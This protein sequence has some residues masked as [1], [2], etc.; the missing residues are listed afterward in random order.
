MRDRLANLEGAQ[1]FKDQLLATFSHELRTL[2]NTHL[3]MIACAIEQKEVTSRI[4]ENYLLPA[5][6]SGLLLLSLIDD[7]LDYSQLCLNT[8]QIRIGSVNIKRICGHIHALF[9]RQAEK[10]NI[11]F[12]Y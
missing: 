3:N 10:K 11:Q 5:K 8:I 2:L 1:A 9:K 7:F 12:S 4:K 6:Y